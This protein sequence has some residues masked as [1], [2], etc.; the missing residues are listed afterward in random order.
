ME[1][2]VRLW[3]WIVALALAVKGFKIKD[4]EPKYLTLQPGGKVALRIAW[5]RESDNEKKEQISIGLRLEGGLL[6]DGN[7]PPVPVS[8]SPSLVTFNNVAPGE[9]KDLSLSHWT[10]RLSLWQDTIEIKGPD[11]A[12]QK[13]STSSPPAT[14]PGNNDPRQT[15]TNGAPPTIVTSMTMQTT[16]SATAKAVDSERINTEPSTINL[17]GTLTPGN[18]SATS[19]LSASFQGSTSSI[20]PNGS[21]SNI[22][23]QPH[24]RMV[25]FIAGP[26]AGVVVLIT[27]VSCVIT[28]RRRARRKKLRSIETAFISPFPDTAGQQQPAQ[29]HDEHAEKPHEGDAS[30]P[31][32]VLDG[33]QQEVSEALQEERR[34][35]RVRYHDDS[36]F[37]PLPPPSD[38]G[39]SSVLDV[40]PRYDAAI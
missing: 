10:F 27:I 35:R 40:P 24:G 19:S 37:R 9:Y 22:S 13:G 5:E 23:D 11:D 36:G 3:I 16:S 15:S 39:D 31:D 6:F 7:V 38:A 20:A 1:L 26:I 21:S 32:V 25:G 14:N 34:E 12:T 30:S 17:S 18:D 2:Q 4:V 28:L 8:Q 29:N 33:R